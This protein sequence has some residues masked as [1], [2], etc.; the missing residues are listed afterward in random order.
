MT[1]LYTAIWNHTHNHKYAKELRIIVTFPGNVNVVP[2]NLSYHLLGLT[3][4]KTV[5]IVKNLRKSLV[6]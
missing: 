5:A 1:V 4:S 2:N 6:F 3:K